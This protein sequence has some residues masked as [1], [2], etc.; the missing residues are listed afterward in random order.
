MAARSSVRS[1]EILEEI[2]TGI[3][4]RVECVRATVSYL[5]RTGNLLLCTPFR[6]AVWAST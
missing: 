5:P 3:T 1:R 2:R 4:T 6:E